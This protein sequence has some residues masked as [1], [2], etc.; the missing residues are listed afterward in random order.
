MD[1]QSSTNC[2]AYQLSQE[3]HVPSRTIRSLCSRG[4]VPGVRRT[5]TGRLTFTADQADWIKTLLRLQAIGFD[6]SELKRYAEL[7]RRGNET[8]PERKALLETKKRQIWQAI[9]AAERN[10]DF[11]E[12]QTELFDQALAK[13]N[14][15]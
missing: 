9:E 3:F 1:N 2:T 12:R 4:L 5:L 10:I 7:T 15:R 14:N 6:G 13:T 11:I 8:I